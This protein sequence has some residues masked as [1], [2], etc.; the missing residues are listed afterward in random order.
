MVS[1][2]LGVGSLTVLA[3][4]RSACC[5]VAVALAVLLPVLG[6]NWSLWLIVAVLVWAAGLTTR[7]S[8]VRV[9]FDPPARVPTLHRPVPSLYEPRL[10]VADTNWRPVGNR[11]LT[12]TLVAASG[13]P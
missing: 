1:P 8:M 5:G 7:A 12:A 13:P 11:S 9:A 10:G 2:T 6:S 4:A 3:T